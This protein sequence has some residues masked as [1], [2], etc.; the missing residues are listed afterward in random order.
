[1]PYPSPIPTRRF[2]PTP[3]WL[4]YGLLVV[5]GLLWLSPQGLGSAHR[6]G[7]RGRGDA[8][9]AR[10]VDTDHGG[11]STPNVVEKTTSPLGFM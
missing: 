1:M 7:E 4:I 3:T 2:R 5:E 10:L 11:V 9:H 8:A 6:R